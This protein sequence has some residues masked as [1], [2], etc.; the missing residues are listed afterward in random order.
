[1]RN[2]IHAA[3][4]L[5]I[6]EAGLDDALSRLRMDAGWNT[7]F[8]GKPLAGGAYTV[9][10]ETPRLAPGIPDDIA[11]PDAADAATE[12][13]PFGSDA[14]L[15]ITAVA[16]S[17]AGFVARIEAELMIGTDGPPYEVA[18]DRIRVNE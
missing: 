16:T 10:V 14:D 12:R 7:G 4:A 8:D 11:L 3:E 5:A 9:T 15:L 6:A 1:M 2:H 13:S 17:A 18:I